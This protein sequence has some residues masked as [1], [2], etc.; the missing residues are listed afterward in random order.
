MDN[1]AFLLNLDKLQEEESW[2][3]KARAWAHFAAGDVSGEK[4][5]KR[6]YQIT[7]MIVDN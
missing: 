3:K 1:I 5:L 4:K 7:I 6:K 2:V